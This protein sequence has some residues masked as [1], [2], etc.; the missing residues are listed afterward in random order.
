MIRRIVVALALI[1]G[2]GAA[3]AQESACTL[4]KV[5]TSM[6]NVAQEPAGD[7]YIDALYDGD[8]ACV[9]RTATA[10][11]AEW[12]FV[13]RKLESPTEGTPIGGW[14]QLQELQKI[15]AA[16]ANALLA[17][18]APSPGQSTAVP[19]N[20]AAKPAP[21]A[22]PVAP[23]AAATAPAASSAPAA[24]AST[25]PPTHKNATAAMRP[26]D[27]LHFDQPIPFGP[28]PVNG[29]SIDEMINTVPLFSP[30]EGLD[31]NLWKKKCTNCHQWNKDRLCQQALTYVRQPR[32]V[33]R[34]PH[35]FGGTLKLALMRWAKSGCP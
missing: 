2:T 32:N 6:L 27:V 29:H 22:S 11:G 18:N 26:E 31:E 34:V 14:A 33:L 10:K 19:P 24:A 3:W 20:T 16:E 21:A 35:P 15:S 5:N 23:P 12:A 1:Y 28:F 9:T 8:V 7:R 30:V 4:F 17:D 13:A 25:Q